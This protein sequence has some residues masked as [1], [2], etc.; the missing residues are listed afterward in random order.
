MYLINATEHFRSRA[1]SVGLRAGDL[2]LR[3]KGLW[4]VPFEEQR[5]L[6]RPEIIDVVKAYNTEEDKGRFIKQQAKSRGKLIRL[7]KRLGLIYLEGD[8]RAEGQVY[9]VIVVPRPREPLGNEAAVAGTAPS[10]GPQ[11]TG[12]AAAKSPTQ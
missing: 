12:A 2:T 4:A 6:L 3:G 11:K 9:V 7:Q 5:N 10:D 8:F 1:E